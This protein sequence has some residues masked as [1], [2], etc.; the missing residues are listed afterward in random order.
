MNDVT[1]QGYMVLGRPH[2][3]EYLEDHPRTGKWLLTIG[4][5]KFP[6]WGCGTRSKWPKWNFKRGVSFY[7][8]G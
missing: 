2:P 3:A 5:R 1:M 4:D 8:L 7:L 6:K